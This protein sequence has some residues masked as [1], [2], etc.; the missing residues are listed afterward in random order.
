MI[1]PP[2]NIRDFIFVFKMEITNYLYMATNNQAQKRSL[3][4]NNIH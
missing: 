4:Y 2:T 1:S 3:S